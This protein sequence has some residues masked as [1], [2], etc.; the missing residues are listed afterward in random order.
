MTAILKVD[1]IQD[2]SGNLIIKEDS[3]TITVGASG[4]TIALAGSTVTGITQGITMA[5]QWRVTANTDNSGTNVVTANWERNDNNFSL[6]GTGMTE[7]SGV[8]TFSSTGIY[9][10]MFATMPSALSAARLYQGNTIQLSTNSGSSYNTLAASYGNAYAANA[11]GSSTSY[12]IMDITSTSTHRVR[13]Q[14]ASE[15]NTRYEGTTTQNWVVAT[16]IRLGDT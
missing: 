3:N 6:I 16:F 12:A 13:F 5:D 8:F 10:V 14:F 7:N 11:Y 4:D 2:T 1:E 15:G 9:H